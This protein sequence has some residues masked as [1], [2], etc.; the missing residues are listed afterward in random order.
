M[1]LSIIIPS[2]NTKDLIV[3]CLKSVFVNTGSLEF[4]VIVIDNA[5]TDESLVALEKLARKHSN[6]KLIKNKENLGFAE[7][8][9]Q[10][11]KAAKGKYLLF[12]NSDTLIKDKVL[13]EMVEWMDRHFDVGI[14]T[15]ALRNKDGSIQGTGGYFPTLIRVFSW[16]TIQ[17]IPFVDL[18]IKP[19]HPLKPKA[20]FKGESF[21]KKEREL[22]WLTGAFLMTRREVFE[23]S[24]NSISKWDSKYFMYF[25]DVDLCFRAKQKGWKI[26]FLPQWS[27]VHYGGASSTSEF[28]TV[29]EFRG[30]KRFYKKF[31]PAWQYPV[32][33]VVLKAGALA[34]VVFLFILGDKAAA[35]IYVKAFKE[36]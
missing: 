27:I 25:E 6:L 5:S 21:Y 22:D 1:E 28:S 30:I 26:M 9:N 24:K 7:V 34:R 16:M 35:L 10:G 32:V 20:I 2:F 23:D 15:C 12:L 31:Y 19:F 3:N 8:N 18:M 4:E 36:I 14:A 13:P 17:D 11:I 29:S 33:R